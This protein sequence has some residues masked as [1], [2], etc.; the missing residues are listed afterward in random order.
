[1]YKAITDMYV[2]CSLQ[3][4]NFDGPAVCMSDCCGRHATAAVVME[5]G[6][7][8]WRCSEHSSIR[9]TRYGMSDLGVTI[10]HIE[11]KE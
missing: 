5:D 2:N 7:K 11:V 6:K 3:V 4:R 8:M 9:R 1:M 10:T